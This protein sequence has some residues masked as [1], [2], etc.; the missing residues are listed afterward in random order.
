LKN[1]GVLLVTTPNKDYNPGGIWQ[2]DLPPV[3]TVWLGRRGCRALAARCGL[4][5]DFLTGE[6][7][8]TSENRLAIFLLTRR[9]AIPRHRMTA[10]GRTP[11]NWSH[12]LVFQLNRLVKIVALFGPV[13]KTCNLLAAWLHR[14]PRVLCALF[15]KGHSR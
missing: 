6:Y 5:V 9:N 15:S 14:E 13:R 12:R 7:D 1:D 4:K 8:A 11:D 3:H 10:H 2:T